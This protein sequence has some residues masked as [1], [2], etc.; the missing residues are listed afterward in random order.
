[1]EVYVPDEDYTGGLTGPP[2]VPTLESQRRVAKRKRGDGRPCDLRDVF[3]CAFGAAV[4]L[5]FPGL[6]LGLRSGTAP[7]LARCRCRAGGSGSRG[8]VSKGGGAIDPLW[9]HLPNMISSGRGDPSD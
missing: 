2:Q 1:M 6:W 9:Q 5:G 7:N 3:S 8:A 4:L